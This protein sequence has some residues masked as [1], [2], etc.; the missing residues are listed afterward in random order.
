M[1]TTI[2]YETQLRNVDF[3]SRNKDKIDFE[4]MLGQPQNTEEIDKLKKEN[5]DLK[6]QLKKKDADSMATFEL[7]ERAVKDDPDVKAMRDALAKQKSATLHTICLEDSKYLMAWT[8][9]CTSVKRAYD[10]E[11]KAEIRATPKTEP[12]K[13]PTAPPVSDRQEGE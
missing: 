3:Y 1:D 12:P 2:D 5:A 10:K 9:Y 7:M 4:K 11:T 8:A 13:P 6:D